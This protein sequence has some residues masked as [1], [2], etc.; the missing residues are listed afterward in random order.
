MPMLTAPLQF[1]TP[2]KLDADPAE[3]GADNA[4]VLCE[5]LGH[6]RAELDRWAAEKAV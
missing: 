3:P 2:E 6:S 4:A 5:L 1:T